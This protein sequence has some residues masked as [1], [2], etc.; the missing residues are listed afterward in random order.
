MLWQAA[1]CRAAPP[2]LL[3]LPRSALSGHISIIV[4]Q[5]PPSD[6]H[7]IFCFDFTRNI[8]TV[9]ETKRAA[10]NLAGSFGVRCFVGFAGSES[11]WFCTLD[12]AESTKKRETLV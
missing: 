4:F 5:L 11:H 7:I 12:S 10:A 6:T 8:S 3:L 2:L 1:L 9:E